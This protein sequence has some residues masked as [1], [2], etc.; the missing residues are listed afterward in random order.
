MVIQAVSLRQRCRPIRHPAH[1]GAETTLYESGMFVPVIKQVSA[2][3]RAWDG[4]VSHICFSPDGRQLVL[5]LFHFIVRLWGVM[6]GHCLASMQ[7]R[8][9]SEFTGISFGVD[10]TSIIL[11]D[12]DDNTQRWTLSSDYDPNHI[13]KSTNCLSRQ[14]VVFTP[15]QDIEP[16]IFPDEYPH[17]YH[18]DEQR[19][20]VLG[21]QDRW[22]LSVLPDSQSHYCGEKA[23]FV[24][25]VEL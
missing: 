17:Q 6:T 13:D 23:V 7:V 1:L 22:R 21:K 19:S 15:I 9:D 3:G 11:R 10:G 14:S 24:L 5:L 8:S 4:L 25:V 2:L 18:C 20:W 16:S 12:S